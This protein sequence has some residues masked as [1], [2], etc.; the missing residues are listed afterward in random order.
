[1]LMPLNKILPQINK[2]NECHSQTAS[3]PLKPQMKEKQ[4]SDI[5]LRNIVLHR[6]EC[7]AYCI[8]VE[9]N[10]PGGSRGTS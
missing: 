8:Q 3:H 10:Q 4:N 6:M 5:I 9:E 1:M 7:W 2:L